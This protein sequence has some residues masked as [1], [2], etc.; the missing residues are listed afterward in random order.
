MPG[1]EFN[2]GIPEDIDKARSSAKFDRIG[3]SN[4][5]SGKDKRITD[6]FTKGSHHRNLSIVYIVQI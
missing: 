5:S 1:I 2:E 3:R 6:L 4:A